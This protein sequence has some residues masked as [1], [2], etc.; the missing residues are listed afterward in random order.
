MGA[1]GYTRHNFPAQSAHLMG[2]FLDKKPKYSKLIYWMTHIFHLWKYGVVFCQENSSAL[3]Q[4]QLC[5]I[6][7]PGGVR[8]GIK[9][10]KWTQHPPKSPNSPGQ[11]LGQVFKHGLF[12]KLLQ[13]TQ[14]QRGWAQGDH[15]NATSSICTTHEQE[16]PICLPGWADV[17]R[18]HKTL[19]KG[20]R[21]FGTKPNVWS[22]EKTPS[23]H[24]EKPI[25]H[26]W[27]PSLAIKVI[28][29]GEGI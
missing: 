7:L 25:V 17:Q 4:T 9:P 28:N 26:P 1:F 27:F 8:R 16:S 6:G 23:P 22:T 29:K 13:S 12:I 20:T 14:N 11:G 3:F 21:I 2:S 10:K 19:L 24:P 18:D 5:I 15:P